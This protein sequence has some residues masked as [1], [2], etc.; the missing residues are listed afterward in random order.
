MK[1]KRY[2]KYKN[3]GVGWIGEV[4]EEW[5]V[6]KLFVVLTKKGKKNDDDVERKM[7]SVS[8]TLG[9]IEKKYDSEIQMRTQEESSTYRVVEPDDLVVNNMWIQYRGLGVSSINGIVSPAYYVYKI[10]SEKIS[11]NF[12]NFLVRSDL[13]ANEYRRWLQGIRPNSLQISTYNFTR[14]PLVLPS[15]RE[16]EQIYDFLQ[17]VTIQIDELIAKSKS[18]ITLLKEKRQATITQAVT[19]GLDPSVPMKDS[20]VGWIGDIP[21]GWKV[22]PLKFH[23]RINERKLDD[24]TEDELEISYIDVGSVHAGG[25]IDDPEIMKFVDA[26]SRARRIIK[27][28]DTILSTVRTYLKAIAFVDEKNDEKICSTGFA[29]ISPKKNIQSKFLYYLLSSQ[30]HIDHIAASSVGIAYPAINA[31]DLGIFPILVL[32]FDEAQEIS[33]FLDNETIQIDE[34]IAKSKSQITLLKEKRQALITA[35]VTGKIDVRNMVA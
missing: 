2:P 35:T 26:P 29:V 21:E 3:S 9:I 7:L 32:P 24:N 4:P 22:E 13:Y 18:Q 16:Q 14:L 27:K 11:P 12:L 17:N 1:Y 6:K 33:E 10:N 28:N 23:V 30:H 5:K 20:G 25:K 31:S 19:K 34:L 15:R 8:Q